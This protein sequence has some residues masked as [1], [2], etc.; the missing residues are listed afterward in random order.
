MR[1]NP[2][3]LQWLIWVTCLNCFQIY[4]TWLTV[5][6]FIEKLV[7]EISIM[8]KWVWFR[9]GHNNF[10]CVLRTTAYWAHPTFN[11]FLRR[12]MK[13]QAHGLLL[14][15]IVEIYGLNKVA[16]KFLRYVVNKSNSHTAIL[17]AYNKSSSTMKCQSSELLALVDS[18]NVWTGPGVQQHVLQR[19]Q[20]SQ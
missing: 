16:I 8:Q 5:H 2:A 12:C 19:E 10:A 7:I 3:S 18:G 15:S 11:I 6:F 17:Y 1:S 13:Y 14:W 9:R 4:F 20:Q